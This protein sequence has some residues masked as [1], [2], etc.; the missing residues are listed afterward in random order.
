M[1]IALYKET[2][3]MGSYLNQLIVTIQIKV[4]KSILHKSTTEFWQLPNYLHQIKAKSF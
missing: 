3:Q 2:T 1:N 4:Q